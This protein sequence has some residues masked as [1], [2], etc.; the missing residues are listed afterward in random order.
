MT[1]AFKK[2]CLE[3]LYILLVDLLAYLYL[4]ISV[5]IGFQPVSESHT[6]CLP[7]DLPSLLSLAGCLARLSGSI[8]QQ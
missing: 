5:Q 6:F 7:E 3:R 1:I 4:R 8:L 2:S